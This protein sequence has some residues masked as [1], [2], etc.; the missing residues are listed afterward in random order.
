DA[1]RREE[2]GEE[3]QRLPALNPRFSPHTSLPSKT[4]P[5]TRSARVAALGSPVRRAVAPRYS[6][7]SS[8]PLP[9]RPVVGLLVLASL[10]MITVYFRESPNGTLHG[11]QS[12]G[13]TALRP[14][15]VAAN[16]LARPFHDAYNWTA[17]VFHAKQENE[18][19]KEENTRLRQQAIQAATGA[20][21]AAALQKLLKLKRAPAYQDY[22]RTAVTAEGLSTPVG[23]F[24][25]TIVIPAGRS[26]GIRVH[27]AVVTERGLVGQVTK[28]LHDTALVTLL[29]DK[30]SKVTAK[31]HQTTATGGG[32]HSQGPEDLLFLDRVLKNKRVNEGDL[33]ITAG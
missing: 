21:E 8:R 5:R 16:R 2:P 20:Q 25:Q 4:V 18:Q 9:R 1:A 23:Q 26:S 19:L 24:A 30:E 17:D 29:T 12:A 10:V 6:S 32:R 28:V 13:S 31:A 7:R 3:P 33:V 15:Q 22:A 11:F 27:D 14:F